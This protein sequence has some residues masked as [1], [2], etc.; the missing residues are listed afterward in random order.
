MSAAARPS[1][2]APT[3]DGTDRR[4]RVAVVTG[5]LA[6]TGGVERCVLEDTREL[7]AAGHT[8]SVWHRPSRPVADDATETTDAPE[9]PFRALGVT[10]RS[11]GD[12]RF[13]VRSA[14]RDVA[15]FARDGL[16]LRSERPD[17]VWLN[18]PEHLPWGR[19]VSVLAGVPLVVHLHHA[20]NYRRVAPLARG[21]THFAAVSRTMARAWADVGVPTD[22]IS[23]V[24]NGVDAAAF[25]AAS[26][27][28]RLRARETFG[29]APDARAVLYY[30]RLTRAKGVLALLEAWRHVLDAADV[31]QPV[32]SG[33]VGRSGG[34]QHDQ[35]ERPLLVLAGAMLPG[36]DAAVRRA[37]AA[38]PSGSV[39]VLPE[40]DDVVPLLHAAD[41][42]VAPSIEPEGFGR[43]V[44]EAMSAGVPVVAA[45]TGGTGE[46]LADG[47][48]RFTVDPEDTDALARVVVDALDEA[49]DSPALGERARAFV[50]DH[51]G[52]HQHV[53]ALLRTLREHA[54]R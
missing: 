32:A 46:I 7:V 37:V 15:R 34:S 44:V 48:A 10:L 40:R 28:D 8:V 23:V 38:L 2:S 49:L 33:P 41:L 26:A 27:A 50:R 22:R 18:R 5:G 53:T 35:R 1:R 39:L 43:T 14:L 30:G 54:R 11:I 20:P 29:I 25:P 6:L 4:L 9:A 19:V 3:G 36:E 52:R 31:R 16:R 17:V 21:R 13:G 45:A 12:Q 42:V 51:H 47:W 24:P